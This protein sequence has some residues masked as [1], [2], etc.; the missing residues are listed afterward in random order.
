M[1]HFSEDLA[2]FLLVRGPYAWLGYRWAPY[3]VASF[4]RVC[5]CAGVEANHGAGCWGWVAWLRAGS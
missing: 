4:E 1:P 2:T 5:A 3:G